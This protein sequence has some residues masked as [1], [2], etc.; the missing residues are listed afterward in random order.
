MEYLEQSDYEELCR[1][2]NKPLRSPVE[3]YFR[4][5]ARNIRNLCDYGFPECYGFCGIFVFNNVK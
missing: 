2:T 3:R 1:E 4:L 5:N